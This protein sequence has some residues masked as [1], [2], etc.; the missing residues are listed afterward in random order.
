[1][2]TQHALA[3]L[4]ALSCT[5][6]WAADDW[7]FDVI[8][9]KTGKPLIG[10][11]TDET[12]RYLRMKCVSRKPGAPTIVYAVEVERSEVDHVELL[13]D[14]ERARLRQRL[15]NLR[16]E[17]QILVERLHSLD[18]GTKPAPS[19]EVVS[20][21]R[22][23]WP[24]DAKKSAWLHESTHFRLL[25]G[26]RREV[27]ELAAL[28][29]TQIYDCYVRLLPPRAAGSPTTILLPQSPE[30]YQAIVRGGGRSLVNPAFFDAGRNEVV[31]LCNLQQL[32]DELEKA[33]RHHA[34]LRTE[35]ARREADLRQAYRGQVPAE[36]VKLLEDTRRQIGAAESRN[37]AVFQRARRR[38]FQRLYHE[39][40]HA[41][42]ARFVYPADGPQPPRWLN[43]GLAQ[44]FE[45]ALVE[46]GELRIGHADGERLDAVRTALARGHLLPLADLLRSQSRQFVVAHDGDRRVSDQHY[47]ASWALA[48]YLTFERKALGEP[49]DRYV[50]ALHRGVDPLEA[51]RDFTG[52]PLPQLE[53]A[54]HDYLEH[55]RPDGTV[56]RA[57]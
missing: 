48:F 57:E 2:T 30:E 28:H 19:S 18:S 41:Y 20:L 33:R 3:L 9:R 25:S 55:L 13:G 26:G 7:K 10:L 37:K 16:R 46:A 51:F 47:L 49:M 52:Q 36:T 39:A 40:F 45:T 56:G 8:Y 14:A 42:L 5:T 23:P 35:V 21:R 54:F 29:L 34:E 50:R 24:G 44:I 4:A 17:R 27:V 6:A 15:D 38:L 32:A 22:V 31:C 12:P 1:V 11:V 43:E 53:K